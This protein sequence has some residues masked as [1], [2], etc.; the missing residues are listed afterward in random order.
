MDNALRNEIE[1]TLAGEK[2]IMRASFSAILAIEKALGKS[3]TAI[4]NQVAA[5]DISITDSAL[6]I[7]HGL[8]GN[9]DTRLSFEQVGDAILE[10]G[11]G[12]VSIP[13][14]EFV[15]RSL[16]GVTVGKPEGAAAPQ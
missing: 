2:R 14:V 12:A 4:I 11:M 3:M 15:S 5:G 10:A 6:I 16:N 8:V 13:V 1:I 7:Y 9:K